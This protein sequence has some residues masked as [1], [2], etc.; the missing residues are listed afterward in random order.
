M[1]TWVVLLG[2]VVAGLSGCSS[3]APVAR[4]ERGPAERLQFPVPGGQVSSRFGPRDGRPHEGIDIRAELGTP[5]RA[6]A[7]GIVTFAGVQR[8]YGRMLVLLHSPG[9]STAYA[10][11]QS[12]LVS[13]GDRVK[14][15]QVVA[16]LGESGRT[17]GP[18]LHFEV[19]KNGRPVDPIAYFR[20]PSGPA[21][22]A[23]RR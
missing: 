4:S 11:N 21:V 9:F 5:I 6:A 3:R 13:V 8:G 7:A 1:R 2:L 12:L 23:S 22:T 17:T 15:G 19:R 20:R 16:T 14:R 10:H 18:N